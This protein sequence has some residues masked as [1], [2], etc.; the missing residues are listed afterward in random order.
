MRTL[1]CSLVLAA[2]CALG[3]LQ[4]AYASLQ[5]TFT[6]VYPSSRQMYL[7]GSGCGLNWNTGLKMTSTQTN[8]WEAAVKC[9]DS[10]V[11]SNSLEVKALIGDSDWMIG[12]N[13]HARLSG[14]A[15]TT[16]KDTI[17]PWFYTYAGTTSVV[18]NV[19]SPEL[20]NSRDVIIYYP[21]SFKENT[22]KRYKNVLIMHD[23]QNVFDPK[24]SAFGCW[25]AQ[26][27]LDSSIVGGTSDEIL[28]VAP[29]NTPDRMNEYTY[30][31][32]E[33]EKAGGKGDL[34][35]DWIESTLIPMISNG[36]SYRA[37]ISRDTLGILGSS[38]GG[39]IS[40]YA[41]WTRPTVY[42]KVGCMSSSFWWADEDFEDNMMPAHNVPAS[43]HPHIYMDSGTG[44]KGERDCTQQTESIYGV[45]VADGFQGDVE[46]KKYVQDGGTHDEAS[47]S[48][49]FYIPVQYLYPSATA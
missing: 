42:G 39:L 14:L 29:Y 49:R 37:D 35:L 46:V 25:Y 28:V 47:W 20:K 38:L 15:N 30:V 13:H 3:A 7:R 41:G 1:F 10:E 16:V 5:V 48:S 24:T 18:K 19:Y 32:D 26:N 43:P 22:F 23:G 34:Y 27:A 11:A 8:Q 44:S 12:S 33:S 31:Y 17:F 36:A 21:P 9:S 45:M 6:V 2:L 4:G 40:C